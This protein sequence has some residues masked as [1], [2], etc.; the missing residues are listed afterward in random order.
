MLNHKLEFLILELQ[1]KQNMAKKNKKEWVNIVY[2]T[3][4]DYNFDE[5]NDSD[6]E[7]LAPNEQTLRV[8]VDKK[9]RK[10]KVAT[11]IQ[12]FVGTNDDLKELAKSLKASCGVGGS[13]KDGEIIIQGEFRDKVMTLLQD[14]GYKT[15]RVGG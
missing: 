12:G 4:Q 3:N 14:K 5:E 8:L 9:Q 1:R 13:A 11:I 7:T 2:S 15:K 10:G 6:E